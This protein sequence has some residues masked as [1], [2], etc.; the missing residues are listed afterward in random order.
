MLYV[1]F[2]GVVQRWCYLV[3]VG[4]QVVV[5]VGCFLV[6]V[7]GVVIGMVG[8]VMGQILVQVGVVVLVC[9]VGWV[10]LVD[11]GFEVECVLGC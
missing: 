1:G 4:E 10:G 7:Q 9:V 11:V 8:V 2:G 3:Q 5:K 6:V